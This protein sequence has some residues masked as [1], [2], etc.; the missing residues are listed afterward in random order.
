MSN[1]FRVCDI[2][3]NYNAKRLGLIYG[4]NKLRVIGVLG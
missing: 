4:T 2:V 1:Y 3:F